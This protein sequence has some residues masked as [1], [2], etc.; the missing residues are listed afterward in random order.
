MTDAP[1]ITSS[2]LS[3]FAAA[4]D[5]PIGLPAFAVVPA[6]IMEERGSPEVQQIALTL[7][8][9]IWLAFC[10]ECAIQWAA[11]PRWSTLKRTWFD[12]LLILVSPPF[13]TSI[14]LQATRSLRVLR[15]L[16][17][18]RATAVGAVGIRYA[19]HFLLRRTF[20]T[21]ALIAISVVFLGALGIYV[22]EGGDGTPTPTFGDALWWS[23]VTATTV[24][25][26]DIAPRTPEGR[27]VAVLLMV[28]GIGV[29]GVF[30][31]SVAGFFLEQCSAPPDLDVTQRLDRLERKLDAVLARSEIPNSS[32][33]RAARHEMPDASFVE[34]DQPR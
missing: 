33:S 27:L 6:L 7:N 22:L 5:T 32:V 21:V 10:F 18:L 31:A 20:H 23:V 9:I 11:A 4:I 13:L 29:I 12:L 19:R 25:Y 1:P 8:W 17:L 15:L 16:R 3:Q 24:G 34:S 26:G 2:K 28:S 14:G 30:T